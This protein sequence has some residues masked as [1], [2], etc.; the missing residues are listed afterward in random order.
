MIHQFNLLIKG[1][2][3]SGWFGL[4]E[5]GVTRFSNEDDPEGLFNSKMT[6]ENLTLAVSGEFRGLLSYDTN[7]ENG[8]FTSTY[9]MNV[10]GNLMLITVNQ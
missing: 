2:D 6:F 9:E 7:N 10:L 3:W 8:N 5:N 1:A 4:G